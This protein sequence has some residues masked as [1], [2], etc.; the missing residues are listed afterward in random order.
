MRKVL[1]TGITGQ[2]GSYLAE[3]F[4][5]KGWE[6]HGIVRRQAIENP[7]I[8][9]KNIQS[10]LPVLQLHIGSMENQLFIFKTINKC[11]PDQIYHLASASF[12]S[13]DFS[14][15]ENIIRDN[16]AATHNLFSAVREIK[17]NCKVYFAGSS[18]MFGEATHEPQHER[19][20]F[21]PRSIY[22]ISKLAAYHLA[23]NYR[24]NHNLF[25]ATGI[26][27]NHESPR[28][29]GQ[30]VTQKIATQAAKIKLGLA[31]ALEVGNLEAERDWGYAP[32]Y[33]DAMQRMMDQK[34]ASDYVIATGKT[35]KVIDIVKIAFA[36]VGLDYKKYLK[37]KK[38]HFRPREQIRLRGNPRKAFKQLKWR[39]KK[40]L[41]EIIE[42][43]VFTKIQEL[44]T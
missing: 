31:K 10:V 24:K 14:D 37:V 23:K 8:A 29:G 6:V 35:S 25:I 44:K 20:P 22:G 41:R 27:Y 32:E 4:I 3:D 18:E 42:E 30:F 9:L 33:V 16:F 2:D 5:K 15:E 12:V 26:L 11:M 21:N 39:A 36:C 19:T 17:P 13:Y 43:M 40:P 1:I 7:E 38:E 34:I 28:R